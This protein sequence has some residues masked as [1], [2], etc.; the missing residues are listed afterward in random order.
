M[1]EIAFTLDSSPRDLGVFT[2]VRSITGR[3]I[4][5]LRNRVSDGRPIIKWDTEDYPLDS[6]RVEYYNRIRDS[7]TKLASCDCEY[8]LHYRTS[9]DDDPEV[10]SI[11]QLKNLFDSDIEYEAQERD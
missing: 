2:I 1:A 10:V 9:S 7:I 4:M 5:D 11:E 3:S 8:Q 6:D